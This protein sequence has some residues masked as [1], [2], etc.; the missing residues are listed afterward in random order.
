M[1][2]FK[3]FLLDWNTDKYSK[4][5]ENSML[6]MFAFVGTTLGLTLLLTLISIL[7]TGRVY[8]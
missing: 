1:N 6:F 8:D 2:Q 7:F 4:F 5:L 3:Q